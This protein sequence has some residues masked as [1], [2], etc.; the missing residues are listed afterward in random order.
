VTAPLPLV[1]GVFRTIY[2]LDFGL[3]EHFFGL[4]IFGPYEAG[5][6]GFLRGHFVTK[7]VIKHIS[8]GMS[9]T[10]LGHPARGNA[11]IERL[12]YSRKRPLQANPILSKS[13]RIL[14]P[15]DT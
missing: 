1:M 15:R 12:T 4:Y 6:S 10:R 2:N 8:P 14:T 7:D 13:S 5:A 3:Y 11:C 9:A